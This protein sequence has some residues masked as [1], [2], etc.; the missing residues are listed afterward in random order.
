M[1]AAIEATRKHETPKK[2]SLKREEREAERA[3]QEARW[4][5]RDEKDRQEREKAEAAAKAAAERVK[6]MLGSH[7]DEFCSIMVDI[8]PYNLSHALH[9]LVQVHRAN[10][11][12]G[13]K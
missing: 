1:K 11:T 10:I 8:K 13:A 12:G 4:R 9:D 5:A 2:P 3:A 6:A 7:F